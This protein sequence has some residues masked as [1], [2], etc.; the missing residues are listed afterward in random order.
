MSLPRFGPFHLLRLTAARSQLSSYEAVARTPSADR[1]VVLHVL[2]PAQ[3]HEQTPWL[4]SMAPLLGTGDT[5]LLPLLDV[6]QIEDRG[7][8][9][10]EF[11][12]GRDLREVWN[13]CAHAHI[14]FPLEIAAQISLGLCRA[15]S[16][17]Q[18]V[19]GPLA[20]AA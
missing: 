13:R 14:G 12:E 18:R 19:V 6:G 4:Q 2:D 16:S 1:V 11:V 7:Y 17:A 9:M 10:T 8:L 5:N 3:P 20:Y 15:L